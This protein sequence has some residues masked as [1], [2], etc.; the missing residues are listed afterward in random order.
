MSSDQQ[1]GP[2]SKPPRSAL[3]VR[4]MLVALAVLV[5]VILLLGGLTRACSFS[6]GGPTIDSSRLPV[7]DV[8]AELAPI[9]RTV[10]FPVRVPDVPEGW[11]SNNVDQDRVGAD[12]ATDSRRAVRVGYLTPEGRYLRVVQSDADEAG[13]LGT[14]TGPEPVPGTGVREIAGLRWVVYARDDEEPI[15]I[16]ELAG[17]APSR[18]LITGSGSD[19]DFAALATALAT[20][21]P[22]DQGS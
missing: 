6:P 21:E 15:W 1:P 16:A 8:A 17:E 9:A 18:A 3:S 2:P 11:R 7:V 12:G 10:P 19:D 4:D 14:E 20:G 13:L 5:P 22:A